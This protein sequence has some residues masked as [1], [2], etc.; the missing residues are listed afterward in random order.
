MI[1]RLWHGL[2]SLLLTRI[3]V[4]TLVVVE[5][6]GR[7]EYGSGP[8]TATVQMRSPR[9]WRMLMRGS[10]GTVQWGSCSERSGCRHQ[11]PE[12]ALLSQSS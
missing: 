3:K 4:G 7:R 11:R 12:S 10:R 1:D 6:R 5:G 2:I 9:V 8:P